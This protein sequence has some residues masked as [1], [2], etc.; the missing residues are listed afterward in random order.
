MAWAPCDEILLLDKKF[1]IFIDCWNI[2]VVLSKTLL[3]LVQVM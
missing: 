1:Y 3:N 2:L